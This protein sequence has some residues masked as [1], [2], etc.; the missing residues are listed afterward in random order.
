[1]RQSGGG[2]PYPARRGAVARLPARQ[3]Q[4]AHPHPPS[5]LQ[6]LTLLMRASPAV[7]HR[8]RLEEALWRDSP[9]DSDSLRTHIH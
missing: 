4:P 1:A 6:L 5:P 2:P 8:T 3:R 7:V 9:P